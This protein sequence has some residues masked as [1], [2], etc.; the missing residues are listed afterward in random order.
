MPVSREQD[1]QL[2]KLYHK[3]PIWRSFWFHSIRSEKNPL[4][5]WVMQDLI[6]RIRPEFIVET[7]TYRGGSALFWANTLNGTGLT[8]S[9]VLTVDIADYTLEASFDPL[10]SKY[11]EFYR[12]S[13]TDAS[14]VARI[15]AKVRGHRTLITL[16]SDHSAQHVLR[17]L[18]LYAPLVSRG[19]Y[20]VV[21]DTAM[22]GVPAYPGSFPG[23]LAAVTLFLKE[24]GEK[25][26]L[27]DASREQMG[28][29]FNPG[30]WLRRK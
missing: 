4:D 21:E 26:F 23:P 29:T 28:M 11:V 7:G 1:Q 20:L 15:A 3:T 19:S 27:Q 5:L 14:I 12:G 22:D 30:G 17:E 24:G 9:K 2:M 16:D 13:S 10:W 18:R 6:W 8:G 25:E